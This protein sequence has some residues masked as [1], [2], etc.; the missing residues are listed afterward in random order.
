[1]WHVH[2]I[3]S[4]PVAGV[5]VRGIWAKRFPNN[6]SDATKSGTGHTTTYFLFSRSR[7]EGR[8]WGASTGG[9][10]HTAARIKRTEGRGRSS[11]S[12]RYKAMRTSRSNRYWR[13]N[14]IGSERKKN[15]VSLISYSHTYAF[16]SCQNYFFRNVSKR[17]A[18]TPRAYMPATGFS[19]IL[20]TCH[21]CFLGD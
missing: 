1:M 19:V 13:C 9:L 21:I 11:L 12:A 15:Q 8:P 18:H 4:K 3:N 17:F 2:K 5:Y 20:W 7:Q 10:V 16:L 6:N 14:K